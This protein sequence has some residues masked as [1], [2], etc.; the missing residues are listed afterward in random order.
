M[1]INHT[2]ST[3]DWLKLHPDCDAVWTTWQT[4]GRGQAGNAWESEN[5]KNVLLSLRLRNPQVD[6]SNQFLLNMAVSLA[7]QEVVARLLPEHPVTVKWP[8]DIYVDNRK[9]CG[10]LIEN[11][12]ADAGLAESIVGI[13]L[14]VN[15]TTWLSDAPNPVSLKQLTQRDYDLETVY[16]DLCASIL[17]NLPLLSQPAL[18]KQRYLAC[19]F[20]FGVQARFAKREV[21]LTPSRV[22]QSAPDAFE[23]TITDITPQ[24]ELVLD[25]ADGPQIFHFKQIQFVL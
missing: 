22:L 24:G 11:T 3:N 4:A 9:I 17:R 1:Y 13:G 19:L 16:N 18:L 10:I 5:G 12:I 2:N 15:Q 6:V 23:A 25:T 21:S 7:V 14:N 8:N 20:R